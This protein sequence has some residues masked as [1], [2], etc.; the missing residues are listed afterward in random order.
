MP[1]PIR[2]RLSG[3]AAALALLA[4]CG[5][6][7]DPTTSPPEDASEDSGEDGGQAAGEV[8]DIADNAFS[9]DSL[10]ISVGDTVQWTNMDAVPHTVTFADGPDSGQLTTGTTFSH[11]FDEAGE[12]SYTCTIHPSMQGTVVVSE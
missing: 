12:F 11:T 6:G 10:E 3:A 5:A 4:G 8:V 1:T 9:P 7:Q 2:C